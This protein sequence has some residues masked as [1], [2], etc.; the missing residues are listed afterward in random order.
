MQHL[1]QA[2]RGLNKAIGIINAGLHDDIEAQ[3]AKNIT[4]ARICDQLPLQVEHRL[5][6]IVNA[7][8]KFGASGIA[9]WFRVPWPGQ[10]KTAAPAAPYWVKRNRQSHTFEVVRGTQPIARFTRQTNKGEL[11]ANLAEAIESDL[12]GESA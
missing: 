6:E 9:E 1:E 5:Q 11:Y 2:C 7:T 3:R 10:E 8:F 12:L 4:D